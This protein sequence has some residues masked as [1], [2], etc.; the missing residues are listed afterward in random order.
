MKLTWLGHSCV[1]I[2][3]DTSTIL[4]DPF[5]TGNPLAP[6]QASDLKADYIFLTH[7]HGDHYGDTEAIAKRTGATVV[8]V[9]EV[10]EFARKNGCTVHGMNTGGSFAFPFG[11]V[12]AVPALHSSSMPDGSYGG[13]PVGY[14]FSI[15]G[16]TIYHAG[17]TAVFSDMTL[18]GAAGIDF[19]FVPIGDNYTMGPEDSLLALDLLRP[20]AAAPIHYG[21]F[22]VIAQNPEAWGKS[23]T[24]KLPSCEPVILTPGKAIDL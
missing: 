18:I 7:G 15:E 13:T 22:A 6:C 4:I 24:A 16:K 19:A 11:R 14:L 2:Q 9:H 21:T 5:L 3:T 17:D 1:Q 23:L 8:G 12:K 20:R 10:S